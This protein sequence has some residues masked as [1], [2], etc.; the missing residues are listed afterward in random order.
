[1]EFSSDRETRPNKHQLRSERTRANIMDA[2]EP[3]FAPHGLAGVSMRQIAAAAGVDLPLVAYHF[4]SKVALYNAVVDRIMLDFTRRRTELM[5]EL[6]ARNPTPGAVELFDMLLT[7]WF[8]IVFGPAPHRARLILL[9]FNLEYHPHGEG[10]A[11]WPSDPFVKRF[12]AALARAEPSRTI[13][14][15]HWTYHC[16]TGAIVYFMTSSE[17]VERISGAYCDVHSPDAIR[18]ALMQQVR[19]AFPE[20]PRKL[21]A[22]A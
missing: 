21:N 11:Q 22:L 7:A 12:V 17:R 6:E 4:Q 14:D 15:I 18:A 9:G 20:R 19:N 10:E 13:Q 1:V 3:L 2:A 8:G 16:L 5:D